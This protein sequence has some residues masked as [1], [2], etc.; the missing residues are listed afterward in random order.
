MDMPRR[1]TGWRSERIAYA[2]RRAKD[3]GVEI[4]ICVCLG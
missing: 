4:M 3:W 2:Q 1:G